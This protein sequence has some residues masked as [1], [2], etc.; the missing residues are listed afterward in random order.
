[1]VV[2]VVPSIIVGLGIGVWLHLYF[3]Y[4]R[5]PTPKV[6]PRVVSEPPSDWTLAQ[7]GLLWS[8][9]RLRPQDMVA[10][11]LDLVRRGALR[12][13][14]TPVGILRAGGIEGT[15]QEHDFVVERVRSMAE[16]VTAA[17]RYLIDEVLFHYA[18]GQ[19]QASLGHLMVEGARDWVGTCGRVDGW[20]EIAEQEQTPFAFEDA[21]S[22]QMSR[23]AVALGFAM[24]GL[25]YLL[26]IMFESP[27][28]VLAIIAG[29]IMIPGSKAIRRRTQKA[30]EALASWQAYRDYLAEQLA[31]SETP[32]HSGAVWEKYL[33]HAVTLGT[34][35]RVIERFRMLYPT[36][37]NIAS[38][39]YRHP[40]VFSLG[41]DPFDRALAS[42][43]SRNG[44]QNDATTPRRSAVP[45]P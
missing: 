41:M 8:Y 45:D 10:S 6:A 42:L 18:R 27:I 13:H 44:P 35:R 23:V 1:M 40:S 37:Q 43:V 20:R 34:A 32:P 31:L 25:A 16:R 33:I 7:V 22:K 21:Q 15:D 14:A 11:F 36:R 30:A 2:W 9:G 28:A 39:T 29:G 4:G 38:S 5:E 26:A 3:R 24:L 17:E 12:L 19:E